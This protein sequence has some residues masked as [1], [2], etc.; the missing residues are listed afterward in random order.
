MTKMQ[1]EDSLLIQSQFPP[2]EDIGLAE[3]HLKLVNSSTRW[4][5]IGILIDHN[6]ANQL[7]ILLNGSTPTSVFRLCLTVDESMSAIQLF[8]K[9]DAKVLL[10]YYQEHQ[11][12]KEQIT[13]LDTLGQIWESIQDQTTELSNEKLKDFFTRQ[14]DESKKK[15]R[16]KDFSVETKRKILQLSHGRCMFEG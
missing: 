7:V 15:G 16:G 8:K 2:I 3:T 9:S 12:T 4:K 14:D 10:G 11:L 6:E 5:D 1:P 13:C